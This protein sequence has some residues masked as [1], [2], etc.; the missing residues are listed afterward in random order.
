MEEEVGHCALFALLLVAVADEKVS[1]A[2][3]AEVGEFFVVLESVVEL[4]PLLITRIQRLKNL[5]HSPK[6]LQIQMR[7]KPMR[8]LFPSRTRNHRKSPNFEV[9][10]QNLHIA[11]NKVRLGDRLGRVVHNRDF[12]RLNTI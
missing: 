11:L 5:L 10:L 9:A 6:L 8:I 1:A 4:L 7:R 2:L 3:V 12:D